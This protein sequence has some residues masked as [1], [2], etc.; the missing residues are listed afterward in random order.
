MARRLTPVTDTERARVREL[1]EQGKTRNDIAKL[2]GRSPGT[3]TVI[4]RELGLSFDRSATAAATEAKQRD[5]RA[6][7]AELVDRLYTRAERV[8]ETLE[9][10]EYRFTAT[11]INGIETERLGHVPA[12]D[13]RHLSSSISTH[14]TTAAKLE[15][16]DADGQAEAARSMLGSLAE[17]LGITA[18]GHDDGDD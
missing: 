2:M 17:A 18:P 14:L 6:R 15:A 8:L 12:Q 10:D 9:A 7:R 11:T 4:A 16:I 5:N 1:H 3:V 13:E